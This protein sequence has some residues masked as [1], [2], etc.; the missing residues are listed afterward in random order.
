MVRKARKTRKAQA[1]PRAT[2]SPPVLS[3]VVPCYN[4]QAVL[5]HT[6]RE[7]SAALKS[8][9]A[10]GVVADTSYLFFV[11]DGSRDRT[12]A[13]I[14][15]AHA[16]DPAHVRGLKLSRNVGHQNALLA[17]LLGQIG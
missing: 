11:D 1:D 3:F 4:E 9:I 12:W 8:L 2:P 5:P 6:L 13:L 16:D 7:L 10:D 17:G 14:E 15:E